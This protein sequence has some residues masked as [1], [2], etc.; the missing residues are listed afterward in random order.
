MASDTAATGFELPEERPER[1]GSRMD[2]RGI[3]SSELRRMSEARRRRIEEEE[4]RKSR[5]ILGDDLQTLRQQV[6]SMRQELQQARRLRA[7]DRVKELERTI[8]KAQQLDAEFIYSVALERLQVA[9]HVGDMFQA[10][11][12][13]REAENAR[14]SLP[15][16]NL[17]GLWVG[18]FGSHGFEMVN[19]TY[20]GD[21][22]VANKVTGDR[23]VPKGEVSFTVDLSPNTN[24]GMLH[25]ISLGREASKQWGCRHLQRFAGQ[26]QVA[27]EGFTKS[28]FVDGQLILVNQYF[29]FA[30][31]PIGHQV[32]FGR[33]S[34]ELTLKMLREA[35]AGKFADQS[36]R[37]HLTR[38]MQETEH[39]EDE[40][41]VNTGIFTSH[42]QQHYY[43]Q[44]GCF[45]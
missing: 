44:E 36:V 13:R 17:D 9:E 31:L 38:C 42:D 33:P 2:G 29:S 40:M 1:A 15:Q 11:K 28:Q 37:E 16:F 12:Y 25:P 39:L 21:V 45:E 20:V 18:K 26:G 27:A 34:P 19:V 41:E 23:N 5:F 8:L 7:F 32:F 30:W 10:E 6:L 43:D 24:K 35:R 3:S 4:D 22:L 14:R